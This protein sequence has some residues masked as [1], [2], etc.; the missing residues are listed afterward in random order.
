MITAPGRPLCV[1]GTLLMAPLAAMTVTACKATAGR[2]VVVQFQLDATTHLPSPVAVAAV[3]AAC[4]GNASVVLEPAPTSHLLSVQQH[5]VRYD[6]NHADDRT[7][8][9]L[10]QC[11][12][13]VPGVVTAGLSETDT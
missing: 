10:I 5:P 3:R 9:Q 4:P 2:E 8:S 11:I 7:V 1:A 12:E 13:A 6:A